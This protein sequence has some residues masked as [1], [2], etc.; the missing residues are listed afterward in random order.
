MNLKNY[1]SAIAKLERKIHRLDVEI[2]HRQNATER[3]TAQIERSIATDPDLKNDQQRK[4]R[5][6]ELMSQVEYV[7]TLATLQAKQDE[8]DLLRIDLQLLKDHFRV[9]LLEIRHVIAQTE[10]NFRVA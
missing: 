8:R 6:L 5:R 3:L 7:E 2:R 9:A 10:Q 4:A 1:P